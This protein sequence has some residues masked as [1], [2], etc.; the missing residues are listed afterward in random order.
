MNPALIQFSHTHRPSDDKYP[1]PAGRPDGSCSRS[2]RSQPWLCSK[3]QGKDCTSCPDS[4][5]QSAWC[6][7]SRYTSECESPRCDCGCY[8]PDS[9]ALHTPAPAA[10]MN[11]SSDCT[12]RTAPLHAS[13]FP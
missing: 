8:K 7:C 2:H 3:T 4:E 9:P 10:C 6:S 5:I 13:E 12:A 11:W 1:C